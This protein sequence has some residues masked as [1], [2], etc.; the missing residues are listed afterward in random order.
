MDYQVDLATFRGPLDLLL[1]LVKRNEVDICDIPIAQV[2]EQFKEYLRVIELIDM[3]WAGDFLVM[4]ATLMEIKSRMLLPRPA[5]PAESEADPRQELV[6]QLLEY[7]KF[8]DAAALLEAR[9]ERQASCLPRQPAPNPG[10]S[11]PESL[12][13]PTVE[14][15]DLVS[16]FGRLM[17]ETLALE[18]TTIVVDETPLHVHLETL[19]AQ[20]ARSGGRLPFSALFTPPHTRGRLVGLFLALLE[21]MKNREVVADQPE[22]FG[23]IWIALASPAPEGSAA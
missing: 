10:R 15:W 5:T 20:L 6:K 16:A 23:E 8:K 21:L 12:S 17:R 19:R 22:V 2:A 11:G 7:K 4:A 1:Y 9:A 18:P 13:L 14:L 3:D